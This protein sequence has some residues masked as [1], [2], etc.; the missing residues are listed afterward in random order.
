LSTNPFWEWGTKNE[1]IGFSKIKGCSLVGLWTDTFPLSSDF[2]RGFPFNKLK[3]LNELMPVYPPA[4]RT[5][6]NKK[7]PMCG[8]MND[9][10]A[11]SCSFCGYLF[12][13]YGTGTVGGTTP[14][15]ISPPSSNTASTVD[16]NFNTIP[17]VSESD[18]NSGPSYASVPNSSGSPIFVVSKS[19]WGTI[20]PTLIYL[21]LI[22][23][24]GFFSSF[25]VFTLLLVVF[26]IV[27]AVIPGLMQP[28]R[29]EFYDNS[30]KV[31]RT[32]GGDSELAYSNVS[33]VDYPARGRSQQTVL[34]VTGQR[35]PLVIGKNPSN[36]ELGMDLKQ[37]L[38]SKLKKV[39]RS[40]KPLNTSED[41]QTA[42]NSKP[43]NSDDMPPV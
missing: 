28:R 34:S 9:Q 15:P 29:F 11:Q 20:A 21:F 30:L 33:V 2:E 24:V 25:S 17:A 4:R 7:C 36:K 18:S 37:F 8:T 1:I 32:I 14:P 12:E 19:I 6:K 16:G 41:A 27:V 38:N 23:S 13:D 39:D 31:H 35:R 40:G 5:A 42:D 3:D 26:F 43:A 22:G 10:S